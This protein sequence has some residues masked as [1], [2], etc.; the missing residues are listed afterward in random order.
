MR[1][2][3]IIIAAVVIL[4]GSF[5]S[6]F[7]QSSEN[8]K[9]SKDKTARSSGTVNPTSLGLELSI[10]LGNTPGRAGN[11]L[12][13]TF[14]YSSKVWRV[15]SL[16]V[17]EDGHSVYW[18]NPFYSEEFNTFSGWTTS[19]QVP[20][21]E[22]STITEFP[23]GATQP[24]QNG[25]IYTIIPKKTLH[26]PD[27]STVELVASLNPIS[28]RLGS[29]PPFTTFFSIDGSNLKLVNGTL[30]MPDGS[31]YV[32]SVDS[33][34]N[35]VVVYSDRNG[36][37]MS[38]QKNSTSNQY[39]WID[40]MGRNISIPKPP[41][42][43]TNQL[44]EG[45]VDYYSPTMPNTQM[46]YTFK[47]RKLQYAFGNLG[48]TYSINTLGGLFPG[49]V[50]QGIEGTIHN[51]VV[52]NE[53]VQPDGK[54]YKFYYNEH[55]EIEKVIYPTG[56]QEKFVH[57][58]VMPFSFGVGLGAFLTR[59]GNRGVINRTVSI[60]TN[61]A[62]DLHWQYSVIFPSLNS[63][64]T[65]QTI[66]PDLSKTERLLYKG[67]TNSNGGL[68]SIMPGKT[69]E[70]RLYSTDG[71]L[72]NRSLTKWSG[73]T[74]SAGQIY[75]YAKVD[76]QTGIKI[77]GTNALAQSSTSGY[78]TYLN[79]TR[80]KV[81]DFV[82]IDL[83]T[84]QS[85]AIDSI[86]IGTPLKTVETTYVT[87]TNY[88]SKQ[89]VSMPLAT[90]VKTG[91]ENGAIVAKTENSYDDAGYG[92]VLSGA[93][94]GIASN[95]WADPSTIYRAN[96]T[97]TRVW[98]NI[99][100]TWIETHAQFDQ[101][102]NLRK[103]IDAKGIA[104]E[105]EYSTTYACAYPT[106]SITPIADPTNTNGSNVAFETTSTFD[107]TTGLPLS[108]TD[109]NGQISTI[110]YNDVFLRPT[111]VTPPTGAGI[112]ETIYN[113]TPGNIWVKNRTQIDGTN[114]AEA[115]TYI[116]GLGRAFKSEKFDADGNIFSETEFDFAGRPL[117][118]TNPYRAN[119]A[120]QWTTNVY[121]EQS[122]VK[123]VTL[124]GG[125]TVKTDFG[126]ATSGILGITKQI[127]DQAGKKRKGITDALGR[128][129][130][131]IEDPTGQNLATDYVF[132]TLGNLRKTI[133][134][135]QSRYFTYDSLGRLLYAKQPEQEANT[136]FAFTDPITNNSAWSVKYQYDDNGNIV[137][138]TDAR[139]VSVAGTYDNFN[140]LK[141]RDYSDATPD[142]NFY[143][144]GKGLGTV[145]NYSKGKTTKVTSSVSETRYTSFDNLGKLLTSEQR[146]PFVDTETIATATPRVS[147]Y[148]YNAFGA[149]ISETYPS[150]RKVNYEFNQDGEIARIGGT[151]GT[152]N[153]L[154][155]NA[156]SYNSAGSMERLRLGNG[157]WETAKYNERLQVTQIGLG[158]SA[159][160]T[161]LLKLEFGYGNTT[162]NNGSMRSQKI[163]FAGLTQPFEQTYAYDDLNRLQSATETVN[164]GATTTWKQ[165]FQY[166]RFG[167]RRFDAAN[168]TNLSQSSPTK[169]TNPLINTSD[170]R[171][172]KDQDG[173]SVND[174]DYD[175]TG[176]LTQDSEGKTFLY[177]AENHQKEVLIN[178]ISKGKYLYDGEGRRVKKISSTETTIFVYDGGGQLV[179]EYSTQQSATPQ[180]S[181]LTADHLGSPRI[182]T[183]NVGK[184]IARKDFNAFGDETSSA[185]RT[186]TLG[187]KPEEIRQDYTGYQ[188]DDE[189][190][191]EFA[192][193]RYYNNKHGRFTSVDPLTASASTRDP[194]T[195]NRYS[196]GLNSPY[197]FT[198]P[199][200]L[201]VMD[202]GGGSSSGGDVG[203][204]HL[205]NNK[206]LN[207]EFSDP[208]PKFTVSVSA[209]VT[210][211]APTA[212]QAH[213]AAHL[214]AQGNAS[215]ITPTASEVSS[216]TTRRVGVMLIVGES[217]LGPINV[218]SNFSRA[219]RTRAEELEAEGISVSIWTV[220]TVEGFNDALSTAADENVARINNV[221]IIGIEIFAHGKKEEINFGEGKA[222]NTN[223]TIDDV[224]NMNTSFKGYIRINA[225]NT[226]NGTYNIA[227]KIS[228]KMGITVYAPTTGMSFSSK[229]D[230][231]MSSVH[232]STGLTYMI[233][234]GGVWQ[235]FKP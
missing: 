92:L 167:N 190:G 225:C 54:S 116:D 135:E 90:F 228:S 69:Y 91:D 19:L 142:V 226:G 51:P 216:A 177:D 160:D 39:E 62:N 88:T 85:A 119:E 205:S 125:A 93:L 115:I 204:S 49:P 65:V 83:S 136:A 214:A 55:G 35:T 36:N 63:P 191:L 34:N 99:T 210:S 9:N 203:H 215:A 208:E 175:K 44:I 76:R 117:R 180:V 20:Y 194:Q 217:G 4:L 206:G 120:K 183:D 5:V 67:I 24:Y 227:S 165:T 223:F 2:K 137:S 27:G 168:T 213:E 219:A 50:V 146:T 38:Y 200:G 108:S 201:V 1:I 103:S 161:S 32:W 46:K 232:P 22:N 176:N 86:A 42:N 202:A 150:G 185:Q 109:A 134:G 21:F 113:D 211:P 221:D 17:P 75:A 124:P 196:Y 57:A 104:G 25:Q 198:D 31:T 231:L 163:S 148:Q 56:T 234:E 18:A 229:P 212:M 155:A 173:D 158:N 10:P 121:D 144:D 220:S 70:E 154:Y 140:R 127:T 8:N 188:K 122:R 130:R 61:T 96:H 78:D 171:L 156:V 52:L 6:V 218:G 40:S 182:I 29:V 97:T 53:I 47:W 224:S 11:S 145:P 222:K 23:A 16:N 118:T 192:Q 33:N 179:A 37:K 166:D 79:V 41:L 193:A 111:R 187:Y 7:G 81:F 48:G 164:T 101:Y 152:Q 107:Y 233:P 89:M 209:T 12:P 129:V 59:Q 159:A 60:D 132:D 14:N 95:T 157:K 110:E 169:V 73:T 172:K 207:A 105:T 3:N 149:L 153:T 199:L 26:L 98:N 131:V 68:P 30:F 114:W 186:D 28:V 197:K 102:G 66:N 126:V 13:I 170:N 72:V 84:A 189:S 235:T 141:L 143:Y 15:E 162:Q 82:P 174:Y 123:Q 128:M 77:D 43:T 58:N 64:Y 94:S 100:N 178:G 230:R 71:T 45:D 106:K 195:F 74:N 112:S 139:G 151:K 87:D 181:Y 133:Q 138:T 147:S 184:V 80:Q